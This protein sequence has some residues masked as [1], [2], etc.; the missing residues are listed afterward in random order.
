MGRRRLRTS[1]GSHL[2][3]DRSGRSLFFFVAHQGIVGD[4][5]A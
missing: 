1:R 5:A 4:D 2:A 3:S